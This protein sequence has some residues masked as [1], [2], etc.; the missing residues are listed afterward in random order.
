M[1]P[2]NP[3]N[4]RPVGFLIN[5]LTYDFKSFNALIFLSKFSTL[6]FNL[7]YVVCQKKAAKLLH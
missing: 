3:W 4:K 5:P 6:H 2:V 1:E 7:Q